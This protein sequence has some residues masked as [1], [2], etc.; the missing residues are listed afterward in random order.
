[1]ENGFRPWQ[2]VFA[3]AFVAIAIVAL[4]TGAGYGAAAAFDVWSGIHEPRAF[5][6]GEMESLLTAR[7]ASSLFAF[8][9]VTITSVL[10]ADA[11]RRRTTG[12]SILKFSMPPGGL[13]TL[14]LSVLALIA[15]AT[16]F[17]SIVFAFNPDALRHDLQP[18]S[19]MMTSRTWWLILVAAGIGAPLAEELLFRGLIFGALRS[20]PLGFAGATVITAVSWALLHANY[21]V[22]GLGA[23]TLIGLYLAWLRERT[24]G[25]LTPIVCHGAY[26]SLIILLMVQAQGGLVGSG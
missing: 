4:A 22:Y 17:A 16:C 26:N 15:L 18:F 9:L 23:I 19:E 7:V 21:S 6:A 11:Y 25:L 13:K 8:Q 10:L 24:G 20:S 5:A 12:A 1:M 2:G 14:A 3:T